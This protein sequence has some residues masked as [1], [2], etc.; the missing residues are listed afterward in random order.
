VALEKFRNTKF[1]DETLARIRQ[2]QEILEEYEDQKLTARQLYY[3]HVARGL[4]E[5][6]E[7]NYK[8]ITNLLTDA[9]YAGMVD[10]DSIEDRGREP[11][12]P[13]QFD[14]LGELVDVALRSYRL[15]RWNGQ[16]FHV[17]LW[18]EKQALAGVLAPIAR[19]YH[20]TLMINKGYSSASAMKES[21]DRIREAQGANDGNFEAWQASFNAVGQRIIEEQGEDSLENKLHMQRGVNWINQHTR[22]AVIFYLGDH[23]PS[24]ED[25]VRD[26]H[27]R[28]KEFNVWRLE[29]VKLALTMEQINQFNPPPNPAKITDSRARAY[30]EKHGEHSWELDALPPRELNR[31]VE[32]AFKSV[33]DRKK[34]DAVIAQEESD[35]ARLREAVEQLNDSDKPKKGKG[36][37]K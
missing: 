7:R 10:W 9:R 15:P 23:D 14:G 26:I 33:V 35:K 17:E 25:M 2:M 31:I 6:T 5:N 30:I 19:K 16:R 20:V 8:M 34:M 29:V 21:A 24:G 1:K 27:D 32:A 12:S 22:G 4:L 18:V 36:K 13:S 37:R 3:Q 11:I 28:L